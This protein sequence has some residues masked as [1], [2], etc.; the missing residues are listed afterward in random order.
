MCSVAHTRSSRTH[1]AS[2][3]S[4][5]IP[6]E[7]ASQR[8]CATTRATNSTARRSSGRTGV[9]FTW[10]D[11]LLRQPEHATSSKTRQHERLIAN[12]IQRYALKNESI[13]FFGPVG[14]GTID[15]AQPSFSMEAGPALLRRRFVHLEYWG[16]ETLAKVLATDDIRP[17]LAPRLGATS[18]LEGTTLRYPIDREIELPPGFVAVLS[19]IDGKC[20]AEAI[21]RRLV[22]EEVFDEEL[23]VLVTRSI[24]ADELE[25]IDG[26]GH[27]EAAWKKA[28]RGYQYGEDETANAKAWFM[29]GY[30]AK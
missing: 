16:Y 29:L 6:H 4:S 2:L 27:A 1:E 15:D 10:V 14:W 12:H 13:G 21:A 28:F 11:V 20:S 5:P 18:S 3:P 30:N 9:R 23:E 25:P 7:S 26:V 22:S 8:R 17:R 24:R 19:L